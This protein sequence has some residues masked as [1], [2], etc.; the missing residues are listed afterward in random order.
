VSILDGIGFRAAAGLREKATNIENLSHVEVHSW[1]FPF[2]ILGTTALAE[3]S[4]E[5]KNVLGAKCASIYTIHISNEVDRNELGRLIESVRQTK[6]E[7]RSYPMVNKQ[8]ATSRCLY[9]GSSQTTPSRIRGHLGLGPPATFALHLAAWAEPL[10]GTFI[11][12]VYRFNE[13]EKQLL[14]YLEDQLS[15]ELSPILGKRG[16]R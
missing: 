13:A 1:I 11:L 3:L 4:A 8:A 7:M 9:V 15:V 5:I 6:F 16:T 10:D 14:P 12:D 2:A